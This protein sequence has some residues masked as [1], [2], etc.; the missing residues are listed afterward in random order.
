MLQADPADNT[1]L[2][3]A[4]IGTFVRIIAFFFFLLV[5]AKK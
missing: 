1:A 5:A 2:L 4:M 3:R